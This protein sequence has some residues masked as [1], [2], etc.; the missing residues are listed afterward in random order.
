MPRA[1]TSASST[2]SRSGHGGRGLRRIR[3]SRPSARFALALR[4][5]P[6]RA[7]TQEA[8]RHEFFATEP[9]VVEIEL[10]A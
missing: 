9:A 10:T 2:S 3:S 8:F 7:W 6:K 4:R 1:S 5:L